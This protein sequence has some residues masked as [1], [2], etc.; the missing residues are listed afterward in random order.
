MSAVRTQVL[1]DI[2]Q[3]VKRYELQALLAQG[4]G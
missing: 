4:S 3:K 2:D 1:E